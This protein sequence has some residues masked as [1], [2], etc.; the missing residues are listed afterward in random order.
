MILRI[1][2]T[3][4]MENKSEVFRY[5]KIYESMA[6]AHFDTKLSRFRYDNG[7]EY[8]STEI[9]NYLEEKGIL[10]EF[11]IRYTPQQNGV[12][13]RMNRTI[14]EKARCILLNSQLEFFWTEAVVTAVYLINRSPTSALDGIPAVLWYGVQPN[15]K[16]LRIWLRHLSTR[17]KGVNCRF[18]SQSKKCRFESRSKKCLFVGYC[19]NGYRLWS[20]I[21]KQII[22]GRDVVFDETRFSHDGTTNE[23][24][25]YRQTCKSI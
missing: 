10:Y 14:V 6:T 20:P 7:R 2:A 9:K 3:Y 25:I 15:L 1:P 13:E 16:K 12:A 18:E 4:P 21:D 19:N 22:F 17:I 11:T 24:W 8:L 5:F 23:D